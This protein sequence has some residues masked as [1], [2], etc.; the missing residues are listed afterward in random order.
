M[1]CKIIGIK[2]YEKLLSLAII[3]Y[4][5]AFIVLVS[6]YGFI[7]DTFGNYNIVLIFLLSILVIG[8]LSVFIGYRNSK[9][10]NQLVDLINSN[11]RVD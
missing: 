3:G 5:L 1:E 2:D 7:Y 9:K 11:L 6:I 10:T 8:R 4:P